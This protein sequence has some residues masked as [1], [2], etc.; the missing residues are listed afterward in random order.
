MS[1]LLT[2]REVAEVLHL[3]YQRTVLMLGAEIPSSKVGGQWL[4]RRQEAASG[5][6]TGCADSGTATAR[7]SAIKGISLNMTS[8]LLEA[9]AMRD[10]MAGDTSPHAIRID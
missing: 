5:P 7:T 1:D 3:S 2:S 4:T 6:T 9:I 8:L 10:A